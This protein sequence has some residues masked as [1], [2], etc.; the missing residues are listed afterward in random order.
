MSIIGGKV[1]L[2]NIAVEIPFRE[3][4]PGFYPKKNFN[5]F[6]VV[7]GVSSPHW[8]EPQKVRHDVDEIEAAKALGFNQEQ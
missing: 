8:S 5:L 6:A 4:M 2:K 7:N 3:T 1:F